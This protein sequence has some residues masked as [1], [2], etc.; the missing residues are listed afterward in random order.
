M[1]SLECSETSNIVYLCIRRLNLQLSFE[2]FTQKYK[3]TGDKCYHKSLMDKNA[4]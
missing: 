2:T 3:V 1:F 4:E